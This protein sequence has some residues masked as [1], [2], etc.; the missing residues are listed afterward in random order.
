MKFWHVSGIALAFVCHSAH[1][2]EW[3]FNV[4]LDE[5]PIGQHRFALEE[6]GA[7]RTLTSEASFDVKFLFVNA[8]RYRHTAKEQWNGNCL[9]AIE[10][11][12]EENRE[13]T[14]VKGALDKSTDKA[15]F[16]LQSPKPKTLGD[17]VMTFAYWNPAMLKQTRLLNPQTGE[18]LDTRITA[19]GKESIT[20]KGQPTDAEHYRLEAP[21]LKIDLWYS[22]DQ[23]WLAL[24]STTPEGYIINYRVR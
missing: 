10:A 11:R 21:K 7:Q 1:A 16:V 3:Q 2:Q 14:I 18:Y 4:F 19:L 15:A 20:V 24:R 9:N 23:Q 5:K 17:C 8:Y 6:N 22:S 12:T 13:T